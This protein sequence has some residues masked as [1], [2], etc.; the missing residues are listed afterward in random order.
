M[1]WLAEQLKCQVDN[2]RTTSEFLCL[3]PHCS[4]QFQLVSSASSESNRTAFWGSLFITFK[5]PGVLA[6]NQNQQFA[7]AID[8]KQEPKE[9]SFYDLDHFRILEMEWSIHWE[10]IPYLKE[11]GLPISVSGSLKAKVAGA[12]SSGN[13]CNCRKSGLVLTPTILGYL[14][15]CMENRLNGL[16][17]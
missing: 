9:M 10:E 16:V 11:G 12:S 5:F 15:Q 7:D 1:G 2:P 17:R 3:I 13:K 4:S 6:L 14:K 8:F